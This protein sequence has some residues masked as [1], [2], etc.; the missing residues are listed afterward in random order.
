[1]E[2]TSPS[3]KKVNPPK[4]KKFVDELAC[5]AEKK[6]VDKKK[7]P[8]RKPNQLP[9]LSSLQVLV[10]L[11]GAVQ[12]SLDDSFYVAD[13]LR[14]FY[15]TILKNPKAFNK[16]NVYRRMDLSSLKTPY[17]PGLTPKRIQ[18]LI[19]FYEKLNQGHT[20]SKAFKDYC[21]AVKEGLFSDIYVQAYAL[22]IVLDKYSTLEE[23]YDK[24]YLGESSR[25]LF[26]M[27]KSFI[28]L[29]ERGLFPVF[30]WSI[31]A[32]DR[33][34][35]EGYLEKIG[36][37]LNLVKRGKQRKRPYLYEIAIFIMCCLTNS[38]RRKSLITMVQ[39][40]YA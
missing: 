7:F 38:K 17:L 15:G 14:W 36:N 1:M 29:V 12:Q 10:S 21:D 28:S 26:P 5:F 33:N 30:Q 19:K 35:A 16:G 9:I 18:H 37:N 27:I 8:G 3:G 4:W 40:T 25:E 34:K 13:Y 22:K 23:L 11:M 6:P 2:E 24:S 32:R 31:D 20:Y 39:K